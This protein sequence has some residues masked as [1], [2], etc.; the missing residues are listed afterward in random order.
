M[1]ALHEAERASQLLLCRTD[2]ARCELDKLAVQGRV[3]NLP[4]VVG[5]DHGAVRYRR[6]LLLRVGEVTTGLGQPPH[7]EVRCILE[8]TLAGRNGGGDEH[9]TV[10]RSDH[11]QKLGRALVYSPLRA[12]AIR[13]QLQ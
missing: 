4:E 11:R 8:R 2:R 1:R 6:Q 5:L 3:E 10:A 13:S 7:D 12:Q 9:A